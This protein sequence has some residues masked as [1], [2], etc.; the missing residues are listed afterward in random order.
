[1][2][3]S[4]RV[5]QNSL[6]VGIQP[7][8]LNIVSIFATAYIVRHL[9]QEDYGH[10]V[11]AFSLAALFKPLTELGVRAVVVREVAGNH[12]DAPGMVGRVLTLRMVLSCVAY[13]AIVVTV[14]LLHY[15]PFAKLIIYV[16]C[17]SVFFNAVAMHLQDA[18]QGYERM[19]YI[20]YGNFVSGVVLTIAAITAIALGMGVLGLTFAYV[21]GPAVLCVLMYVFYRQHL[22]LFRPSVDRSA[23]KDFLRKGMPFFWVTMVW[24]FISKVGIVMLSKMSGDEQVAIYGAATSLIERLQIVPDSLGTALFPSFAA[25]FAQGAIDRVNASMSKAFDYL[26]ILGFACAVGIGLLSE[27]AMHLVFGAKYA[28]GGVVL[29]VIACYIPFWFSMILFVNCLGAIHRQGAVLTSLVIATVISLT[30]NL[31]LIPRYGALGLAAAFLGFYLIF[32]SLVLGLVRRHLGFR[33]KV[34]LVLRVM[35]ANAVM[36]G[37]VILLRPVNLLLAIL[38]PAAVYAVVLV[39]LRV[40][41]RADFERIRSAVFKSRAGIEDSDKPGV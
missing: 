21:L 39:I 28:S 22:P 24:M 9:T 6:W 38:V 13:A 31:V 32:F 1:M 35:L 26:L 3:D 25:L 18:F 17:T 15:H 41:H 19:K 5:I 4:T 11:L 8:I 29:S 20:A 7:M 40:V 37:A 10:F 36:A 23:W 34:S 30:G 33:V 2:T 16:G 14:N 12:D 27:Q